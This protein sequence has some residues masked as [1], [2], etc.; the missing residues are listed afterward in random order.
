MGGFLNEGLPGLALFSGLEKFNADSQQANGAVPQSEAVALYKLSMVLT[1]MLNALNKT[2]VAGTIYYSQF[3][4]GYTYTPTPRGSAI[5]ENSYSVTGINIPVG[6]TGGTDTWHVGLWNSAGVLVGR[7]AT[8][9]VTAGTALTI[10]QFPLYQP[11]GSTAGPV[12]ITSGTYYIGLQSNGTTATFR[13]IN[14]PIWGTTA[15]PI[16]TGSKTGSAG[17][18]PAITPATTYTANVGPLASLY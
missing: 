13:T 9:G 7:S 6:G 10:Q 15:T 8:A 4:V 12:T 2:M 18:L 16:V 17:T 11:D 14:S 5:P 3:D 1:T